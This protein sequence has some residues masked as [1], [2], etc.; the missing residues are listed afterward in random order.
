MTAERQ[1]ELKDGSD[2]EW[3]EESDG[4]AEQY[5]LQGRALSRKDV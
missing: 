4:E 5:E 3:E 1:D 2:D